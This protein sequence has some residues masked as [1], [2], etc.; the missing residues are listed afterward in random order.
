MSSKNGKTPGPDGMPVEY[1][2]LSPSLWARIYEVVYDNQLK[3][4]KMTKFQR[5]AHLSLL[6]KSGDR[7]IPGNYRPLT[8]VNHDA[9]LG[10]KIMQRRLGT[11]LPS[12]IHEDQGGFVPGRSIRHW[13]LR[14]QDLQ[15]FCKAKYADACVVLLD[16]A[17]AFDSV[18]CPALDMVLQYFGFGATFREWVKTFY[19]ETSASLLLND[20]PGDPFLLGAGV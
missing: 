2:K 20:C 1:Y 10:P 8:L 17:K 13:L 19:N 4:G 11:V 6:Y 16:F 5:R 7:A 3:K 9:K 15:G 12:I 18:L 14:L